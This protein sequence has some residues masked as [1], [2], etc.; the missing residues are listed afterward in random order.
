MR[1]DLLEVHDHSDIQRQPRQLPVDNT[2]V[3]YV[4]VSG[5]QR[6]LEEHLGQGRP[7]SV[8]L[9]TYRTYNK[10]TLS[11]VLRTSP[12]PCSPHGLSSLV[13]LAVSLAF[14]TTFS[15]VEFPYKGLYYVEDRRAFKLMWTVVTKRGYMKASKLNYPADRYKSIIQEHMDKDDVWDDRWTC[16]GLGPALVHVGRAVIY[17]SE[18]WEKH[19]DRLVLDAKL[20]EAQRKK[21]VAE[22]YEDIQWLHPN[23][24]RE[25]VITDISDALSLAEDVVRKLVDPANCNKLKVASIF[26]TM[27]WVEESPRDAETRDVSLWDAFYEPVPQPKKSGKGGRG[28]HK[29][30]RPRTE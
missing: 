8:H 18:L 6:P 7:Q 13:S 1:V 17:L 26:P 11:S 19:R 24:I 15:G 4:L 20:T 23:R 2:S 10:L 30:K 21:A 14:N 16:A 22:E 29:S 3:C 28:G 5:F 12:D 9:S 25:R 27:K